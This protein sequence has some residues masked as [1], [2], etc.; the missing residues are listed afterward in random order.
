MMQPF[1]TSYTVYFNKRHH[2]SGHVFEQ[3]YKAFVVDK[4]NYLLQVSR[5]SSEYP[6]E[7]KMVQRPQEYKWSS[8]RSYV[9]GKSNSGLNL[10]IMLDQLGGEGRERVLQY[11]EYVEGRINKGE[12]W[13]PLPVMRQAFIGEEEFVRRATRKALTGRNLHEKYGL[14]QIVQAVGRVWAWMKPN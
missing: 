5:Y 2:R 9:Q 13:E 10:E 7:A 11:R 3:R 1:Q 8:Y 6:V 14:L 12:A 4:D